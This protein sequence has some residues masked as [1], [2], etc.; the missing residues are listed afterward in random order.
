MLGGVVLF[1]FLVGM[2]VKANN[3]E[4]N[5]LS[6]FVPH[7]TTPQP[8][9]NLK[10]VRLGKTSVNVIV[11]DDEATRSKGLGGITSLPDN[12]GM[13]FIFSSKNIIPGFWMKGMKINLDFIWISN[14]TVSEI[15]EN[16]QAPAPNTPDNALQV[17]KPRQAIDYVLEVNA[18]FAA[19]NNVKVGDQMQFGQ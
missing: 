16:I 18:G 9:G 1:V 3:G 17:I 6:P 7:L 10:K 5:I 19:K 12:E 13:L 15:D 4:E 14:N 11:A 8:S 2:L